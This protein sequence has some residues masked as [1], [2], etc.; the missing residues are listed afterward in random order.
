MARDWLISHTTA[1]AAPEDM[2][3]VVVASEPIKFG[4]TL[5]P[6]NLTEVPW[7]ARSVPE[8]TFAHV[9]DLTKD[10]S[11]VAL[12]SFVRNEPIV[13]GKVTL[14]GQRAS[15]ST[16]IETGKRAVAIA[17]DDVRGV[18]GFIFP[19]DYVDVVLTRSN[20]GND[21]Q[22]DFSEV[23]LQHVKV[24]AID[25]SASDRPEKP[26]IAKAVTVEVTSEQALKVLL[27]SNSGRLSLIL[28][29]AAEEPNEPNLKVTQGDLFTDAA[30]PPLPVEQPV[31]AAPP[32][33]PPPTPVAAEAP[34]PSPAPVAATAPSPPPQPAALPELPAA[35]S[36][37]LPAAPLESEVSRAA[38]E[39]VTRK[40]T[41]VRGMNRVDYD[42]LKQP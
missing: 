16:T 26:T 35:A 15:L 30:T 4:G 19:G 32:P 41:I 24:L 11:R 13:A 28:R 40:V 12:A 29:H 2:A 38:A 3:T 22:K 20:N 18:A 23:I 10:G 6:D 1:A 9:K 5:G 31:A 25:Q 37:N 33:P 8:N 34:Q 7:P 39:P 17:V 21:E 14:P 27:A 42:V 36:V